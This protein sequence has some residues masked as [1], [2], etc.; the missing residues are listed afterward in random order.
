MAKILM[1]HGVDLVGNNRFNNRFIAADNFEAQLC[2]FKEHYQLISVEQAF[3]GS[4]INNDDCLCL[5]F[6]DGYENN[7][8]YVYPLLVQYD[9]P[10]AIYI[11]GVGAGKQPVLWAD[12]VDIASPS[13]PQEFIVFDKSFHKNEAGKFPGLKK[14]LKS[15][16]VGGTAGFKQLLNAVLAHIPDLLS[17]T[18]YHDYWK[19]LSSEQVSQLSK[20]K[21]VTIGSHAQWHTNLA[22]I[23]PTLAQDEINQSISY[24]Q[25]ITKKPV[26]SLAFPDGSYNNQI[27]N[28]CIKKGVTQLLGS[29]YVFSKSF[30][31]TI[32][33]H[34]LGI[35]PP[36]SM[37]ELK[38]SIDEYDSKL[39][40]DF[41]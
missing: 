25:R 28:Y 7:L 10:A 15:H 3:T 21:L 12:L 40:K 34:R 23:A 31:K 29:H 17:N 22:N 9:I 5:T 38:V 8:K 24:L 37:E 19:L 36:C 6:D 26:Q 32:L 16:P 2:F 33:Q 30:P 14:Y 13:L 41:C 1:Y 27:I 11:T 4:F 39:S 20:S 18:R 35:Y